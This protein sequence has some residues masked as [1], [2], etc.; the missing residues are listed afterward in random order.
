MYTFVYILCDCVLKDSTLDESNVL[1]NLNHGKTFSEVM[2]E[3]RVAAELG[4]SCQIPLAVYCE[5]NEKLQAFNL[6]AK[7]AMPDGSKLCYSEHS[8]D[9]PDDIFERVVDS[10]YSQG[11]RDVIKAVL[12]RQ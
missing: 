11:A 10:L 1:G 9:N 3:R 5:F 4:A 7:I 12:E 6:R 2:L 8:G